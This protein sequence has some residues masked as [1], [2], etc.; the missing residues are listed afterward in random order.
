M[1]P[2][3]LMDIHPDT[4]KSYGINDGDM[5]IVENKRGSIEIKA[6]ITEDI[7]RGVVHIPHGWSK[8]NVNFLTDDAR[9]DPVTGYPALKSFLCRISKKE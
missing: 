4:A 1:N 9:V 2:E 3:P 5:I 7:G 8:A 6:K